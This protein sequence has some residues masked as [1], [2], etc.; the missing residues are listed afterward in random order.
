MIRASSLD[1]LRP[2]RPVCT[3]VS[4]YAYVVGGEGGVLIYLINSATLPFI[5]DAP[6][7]PRLDS[8][9]LDST[10]LDST[11][12]VVKRASKGINATRRVERKGGR[13]RELKG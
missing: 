10:R 7:P 5:L 6:P 11:R 12:G 4:I 8:T 9:R 3:P 13:E 1:N 2:C